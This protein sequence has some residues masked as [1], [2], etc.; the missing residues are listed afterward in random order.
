MAVY[1]FKSTGTKTTGASTVDDWTDANSYPIAHASNADLE[2]MF[3]FNGLADGD[4]LI[5]DDEIHDIDRLVANGIT[6]GVTA[7]LTIRSRSGVRDS[8]T[9]R[10]DRTTLNAI[11]FNPAATALWSYIFKDMTITLTGAHTADANAVMNMSAN[12]Q[13]LTFDNVLFSSIAINKA[14]SNINTS[15]LISDA[16]GTHTLSF[17]N[18]CKFDTI[19]GS[20]TAQSALIV[21]ATSTTDIVFSGD[22]VVDNCSFDNTNSGGTPTQGQNAGYFYMAGNVTIT[23]T[24]T[25]SNST[26]SAANILSPCRPILYALGGVTKSLTAWNSTITFDTL[27]WTG[28]SANAGGLMIDS[29][30][31]TLG[32]FIHT[33]ISIICTSEDAAVDSGIGSGLLITRTGAA[34]T[35]N[36]I[37]AENN[38]SLYGAACYFSQGGGATIKRMIAKNCS[39]LSGVFYNGGHGDSVIESYLCTGTT[40]YVG[41]ARTEYNSEE[42]VCYH[43]HIAPEGG[44]TTDGTR[45]VSNYTFKDNYIGATNTDAPE[46]LCKSSLDNFTLT[47]TANNGVHGE[48]TNQ[49]EFVSTGTATVLNVTMNNC[50]FETAKVVGIGVPDSYTSN[51]QLDE[52]LTTNDDGSIPDTSN[53]AG[54]G[55]ALG[56]ERV[57]VNDEPFPKFNIDIGGIQGAGPISHPFFPI[58][59]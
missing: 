53:G 30:P 2:S 22:T 41:N 28:E 49:L 21:Y 10:F 35:I 1:H 8:C 32:D 24:F 27:T 51:D 15:A 26:A 17:L 23:G 59:L 7:E 42:G 5:L 56:G 57:D 47:H 13:D 14:S 6:T 44:I 37:Y 29:T 3:K 45:V 31:F 19:T 43:S 52:T 16:A 33:N 50:A 40:E 12:L 54:Y 9:L 55:L 46:M 25:G 4:E 58:N 39:V 20:N 36:Y 48:G 34:G 38:R 11:N 18:S